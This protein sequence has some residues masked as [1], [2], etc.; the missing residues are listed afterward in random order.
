MCRSFWVNFGSLEESTWLSLWLAHSKC[1]KSTRFC[2]IIR[3]Q[4]FNFILYKLSKQKP[5]N[6]NLFL[7]CYQKNLF[8]V[9]HSSQSKLIVPGCHYVP[10]SLPWSQISSVLPNIL[11]V[12]KQKHLFKTLMVLLRMWSMLPWKYRS[13]EEA[14][15]PRGHKTRWYMSP[16]GTGG[17]DVSFLGQGWTQVYLLN[18]MSLDD[19]ANWT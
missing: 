9:F 5:I 7:Q 4:S 1:L 18:E 3:M 13:Q 16:H 15:Q 17:P 12:S 11:P 14:L 10:K 19:Q 6:L 2:V 8:S